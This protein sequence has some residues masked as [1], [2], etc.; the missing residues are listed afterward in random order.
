MIAGANV[1]RE[2]KENNLL[3]LIAADPA[4]NMSL[5]DL[6]KTMEPSNYVGRAPLQVE[7]FLKEIVNP[8]LEENKELLGVTAEITV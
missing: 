3:E 2:G 8:I 1:K 5:E 4:F 6:Q 7:N